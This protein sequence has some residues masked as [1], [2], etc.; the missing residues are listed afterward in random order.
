MISMA[1][2]IFLGNV[3]EYSALHRGGSLLL[4]VGVPSMNRA[5]IFFQ[6]VFS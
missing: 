4:S 2:L 1:C 6:L 5:S 3:P